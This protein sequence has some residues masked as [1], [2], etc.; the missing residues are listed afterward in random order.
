[1]AAPG[2]ERTRRFRPKLR[3][4]LID[5][6]LHGHEILGTEAAGLRAEDEIFARESGGLRWYRCMRCDSWLALPPPDHPTRKYPPARD[7]ISLP[8]RGKPLRDRY[9][10]RLI[11]LDRIVHFLVLGA[12]AAAVLLFAGD[13]AALNAE[14]TK[15][16]NDLQGGV[17]GPIGNT[18]H[19]IIHDLRYLFAVRIQNLYL[20]GAAIAAYALLEGVEAIGLW[21]AKRWA[22]YLT[23][24]ATIVFIPY[25]IDELI[26]GV[27]TLKALAFVINVAVAVYLL[28][29]KRLFGLRGGGKVERAEREADTGWAAIE[30][31]TPHGT[32]EHRL[33]GAVARSQE[34]TAVGGG[35]PYRGGAGRAQRHVVPGG[36]LPAPARVAADELQGGLPG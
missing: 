36:G 8:L 18:S 26:K 6:G 13:R 20:V 23:F 10:L 21:F 32:P 25:E 27:T 33:A 15:I 31:A 34:P 9:V 17:G 12:L 28:Y 3:Y 14:F 16:L 4:E 24:V 19:G 5:C 2:T 7:E 11:A 22:E 30:R 35:Q 29:A 1:V